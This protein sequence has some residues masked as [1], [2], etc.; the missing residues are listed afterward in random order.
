[1]SIAKA[2]TRRPT[3][4]APLDPLVDEM[5][6]ESWPSDLDPLAATNS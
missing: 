5:S 4:P 1:M 3:F 6:T 2:L